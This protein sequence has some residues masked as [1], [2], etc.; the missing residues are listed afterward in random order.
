MSKQHEGAAFV[1]D[2]T[3]ASSQTPA[4]AATIDTCF[5]TVDGT[6]AINAA[7]VH[8]RRWSDREILV[9]M[10]AFYGRSG[11]PPRSHEWLLP[12]PWPNTKTVQ[13]RFGSWSAALAAAGFTHV[14]RGN[15]GHD[16][17]SG[18]CAEC[19]RT[20]PVPRRHAYWLE[21][22]TLTEIFYIAG[23]LD[24]LVKEAA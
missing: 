9:A 24:L 6:V 22:F 7:A 15:P 4:S 1:A 20:S 10:C 19:R 11:R 16:H 2:A 21:Q 13:R 23:G 17:R 14:S 18:R 12:G 8:G 5:S 3:P